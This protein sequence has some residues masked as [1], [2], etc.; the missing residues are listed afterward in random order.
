MRLAPSTRSTP[1]RALPSSLRVHAVDHLRWP[2]AAC[3]GRGPTRCV[4]A[5]V[6]LA[7]RHRFLA[8]KARMVGCALWFACVCCRVSPLLA[9]LPCPLR[10]PPSPASAAGNSGAAAAARRG[11]GTSGRRRTVARQQRR[12]G[13]TSAQQ[14]SRETMTH[15]RSSADPCSADT[16]RRSR[17]HSRHARNDTAVDSLVAARVAG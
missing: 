3:V 10:L 12:R 14:H 16:G 11:V 6:S 2:C 7:P 1:P 17:S 9:L 13:E 8:S 4:C 15:R 5:R